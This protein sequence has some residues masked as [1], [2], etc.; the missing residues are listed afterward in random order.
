[1][2]LI[3][4][5]C[6]KR[7]PQ[8]GWRK[9]LVVRWHGSKRDLTAGARGE[10][11]RASC[12]YVFCSS[13]K[14]GRQNHSCSFSS[15][16]SSQGAFSWTATPGWGVRM[17]FCRLKA[18]QGKDCLVIWASP[19]LG[20]VEAWERLWPGDS[21]NNHINNAT[22]A[23]KPLKSLI[24]MTVPMTARVKFC[25]NSNTALTIWD[26]F[27]GMVTSQVYFRWSEETTPAVKYFRFAAIWYFYSKHTFL[28][29]DRAKWPANL[30]TASA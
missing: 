30:I 17:S 14:G 12:C 5:F 9:G 23:G 8:W 24:A 27:P 26:N 6:K 19:T 20:T 15:L 16:L 29:A 21:A 1:M 28:S 25:L 11:E 7:S 18:Q 2:L 4:C 13:M 3:I 10:E 22:L